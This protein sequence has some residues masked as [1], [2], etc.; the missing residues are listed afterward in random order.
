MEDEESQ[1]SMIVGLLLG[2]FLNCLGVI[3][4]FFVMKGPKTITGAIIGMVLQWVTW[5]CIG[6]GLGVLNAFVFN[7]Y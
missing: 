6:V 5:T 7:S 1:G 3:L 4:S 2:F